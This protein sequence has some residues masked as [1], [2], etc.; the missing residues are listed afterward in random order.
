M[1]LH[2]LYISS[3]SLSFLLREEEPD[4]IC[5]PTFIPCYLGALAYFASGSL[6]GLIFCARKLNRLGKNSFLGC[7]EARSP[8]L[9]QVSFLA[10]PSVNG[11]KKEDLLHFG[12]LL[13]LHLSNRDQRQISLSFPLNNVCLLPLEAPINLSS[14]T[15]RFSLKRGGGGGRAQKKLLLSLVTLAKKK[16]PNK[17]DGPREKC[18]RGSFSPCS[19]CEIEIGSRRSQTVFLPLLLSQ[20]SFPMSYSAVEVVKIGGM[21]LFSP[22]TVSLWQRRGGGM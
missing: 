1:C 18:S 16:V 4:P 22:R 11:R 13:S 14:L 6:E 15:P 8:L 7:S 20:S 2:P 21:S 17:T 3:A 5:F 9:V 12:R 19:S 10:S